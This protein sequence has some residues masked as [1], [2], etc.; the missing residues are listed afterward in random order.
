MKG[1]DCCDKDSIL[2]ILLLSSRILATQMCPDKMRYH[3]CKE[4]MMIFGPSR[5]DQC[6]GN[7]AELHTEGKSNMRRKE[8][9]EASG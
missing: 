7:G 3:I 4:E 1:S 9:Q 5:E 8:G 2:E 6:Y